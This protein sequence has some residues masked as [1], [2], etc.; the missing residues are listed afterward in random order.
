MRSLKIATSVFVFL[1]AAIPFG[2]A[3]G[4]QVFLGS[5]INRSGDPTI[6][7][8]PTPS[9]MLPKRV[10]FLCCQIPKQKI[11]KFSLQEVLMAEC[12]YL[13]LSVQ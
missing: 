3:R 1:I 6:R 8:S 2:K 7:T 10:F 5:D 9:L 11:L 4:A 12:S 13:G